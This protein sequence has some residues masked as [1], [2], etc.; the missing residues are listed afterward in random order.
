[1]I[2]SRVFA[3]VAVC[4]GLFTLH[5]AVN[6]ERR[7]NTSLALPSEIGVPDYQMEN[8]FPGLR[9]S[10]PV[11][12]VTPPGETRRLFV[13]EQPG[14][15][16]LIPDV[17]AET[18]ER[19]IFLDYRRL[20]DSSSNEEGLLGLAFHPNFAENGRFFI[21]YTTEVLDGRRRLRH[22]RLS[23]FDVSAT[24]PDQADPDSE[25]VLISQ[26]DENSNHNGGDLHFG[27]DGFLYVALGDEG[28]A[29]DSRLNSQIITKDYFAGILRIDVDELASSLDPN[30]H[31]AVVGHY[32]VPRDNPFVGATSFLGR[33]VDPGKVITEFWAV[34]LRNPWRMSFDPVTGLLYCGDVGQG[35]LEEIDIIEKG[36]NYGWAYFEGTRTGPRGGRPRGFVQNAPIAEYAHGTG[37]FQGRSV[38]GGIVYR[39]SRHS[40][41]YGRYL[42]ADYVSGNIWSLRHDSSGTSEM[43]RVTSRRYTGISAFGRDP[44][45]G[46]VL[47][48]DLSG[49]IIRRLVRGSGSTPPI[50]IPETLS[51]TGAFTNLADLTPKVGIYPYEVNHPFWSDGA[52]KKRWFSIPEL[53]SS[54]DVDSDGG[55]ALPPGMVW[56]KHFSIELE[57]GNP[58]SRRR[59]ETRFLV[60]TV[61][62]AYGL[63][64]R[65]N[66]EEDEAFLVPEEGDEEVLRITR[67]D[68]QEVEQVWRYPSRSSCLAC[69]T[70]IAGSALGFNH[71]QLNRESNQSGVPGNQLKRL[72]K[73]GF[74]SSEEKFKGDLWKLAEA[75]DEK[76]SLEYRVR[77]YLDVNCSMCHQPGG[78]AQGLFDARIETKTEFS[79]LI[80]GAVIADLGLAGARVIKAGDPD[81]SILLQRMAT[82]GQG[83]MPPIGSN[84]V[85]IDGVRLIREWLE[86]DLLTYQTFDDWRRLVF[87]NVNEG[88]G[89]RDDFDGDGASNF[90]EY[91]TNTNAKDVDSYWKMEIE[92]V[93]EQLQLRFGHLANK[94]FLLEWTDDP[95]DGEWTVDTTNLETLSFT[96][97]R[98]TEPPIIPLRTDSP[99]RF[100][101][102]RVVRP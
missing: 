3:L 90:L 52:D 21:F 61:D 72:S 7:P 8:A 43:E 93:G 94:R 15:I 35:A 6:L 13:V 99:R 78:P 39:G 75:Q 30:P 70:R 19:K 73:A 56:I 79:G 36:G 28:A 69:H 64:Y 31:P 57:E 86:Q 66:D 55:W 14:I 77:S 102:L 5:G 101:R 88:T 85:D 40:D 9:F 84:K 96:A 37:P 47:V 76:T 1:M 42:F 68:G 91:L 53:E 22:D 29:N 11:A 32:K 18:L 71:A 20:V 17:T 25:V 24:N 4:L 63:T 100:Y 23:R 62:H 10:S 44:S 46:D 67:A 2:N 59:L 41:L 26:F 45:N 95:A 92:K 49:G 16:S 27:P 87:G 51:A 33:T 50:E 58:R 98:Q 65:W 54:I 80:E 48:T 97:L 81:H 89:R 83:K 12:L 38:T 82:R 74:F 60:K 34:G